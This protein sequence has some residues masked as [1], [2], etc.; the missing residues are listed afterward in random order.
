ML[1]LSIILLLFVQEISN[2]ANER[3]SHQKDDGHDALRA[4]HVLKH[5]L[6]KHHHH[7]N[8][9]KTDTQHDIYIYIRNLEKDLPLH[10]RCKKE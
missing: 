8:K 10:C 1:I 7:H 4:Y 5:N 6:H 3:N 2:D 9:G